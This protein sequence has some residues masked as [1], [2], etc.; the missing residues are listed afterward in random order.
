MDAAFSPGGIWG[1][2][3]ALFLR[4]AMISG[5]AKRYVGHWMAN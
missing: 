1:I 4:R 2:G 5:S 3:L